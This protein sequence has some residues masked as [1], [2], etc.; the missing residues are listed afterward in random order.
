[1]EDFH[2]SLTSQFHVTRSRTYWAS[3]DRLVFTYGHKYGHTHH[4]QLLKQVEFEKKMENSIFFK[5]YLD[6]STLQSLHYVKIKIKNGKCPQFFSTRTHQLTVQIGV[7]SFDILQRIPYTLRGTH[8]LLY[9]H[10]SL[11]SSATCS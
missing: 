4:A 8:K 7:I 11:L 5:V 3:I 2:S 6:V 10:S 9:S 1:M